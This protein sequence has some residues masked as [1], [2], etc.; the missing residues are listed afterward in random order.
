MDPITI[1]ALVGGGLQAYS[2]YEQ[3]RQQSKNAK[4]QADM[5]YRQIKQLQEL[6]SL[7]QRSIASSGEVFKAQQTS[8]FAK[9]G[10]AIG[11]GSTLSAL[12]DTNSKIQEE[13]EYNK[14]ENLFKINQLKMGAEMDLQQ[15]D[16]F[17]RAGTISAG[18]SLLTSIGSIYKAKGA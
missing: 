5:Q 1:M 3:S 17:R 14:R 13:L 8:S 10:V 2:Q 16:D 11:T 7:Q 18:T 4:V 12:E 15:A 9:G 6:S